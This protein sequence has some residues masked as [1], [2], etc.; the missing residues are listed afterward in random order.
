[1][2]YSTASYS[3]IRRDVQARDFIGD[4]IILGEER[5]AIQPGFKN[6]I[7]GDTWSFITNPENFGLERKGVAIEAVR[8]GNDRTDG[9]YSLDWRLTFDPS[10]SSTKEYPLVVMDIRSKRWGEVLVEIISHKRFTMETPNCPWTAIMKIYFKKGKKA[11]KPAAILTVDSVPL[12]WTIWDL[13]TPMYDAAQQTMERGEQKRKRARER[14]RMKMGLVDRKGG[15]LSPASI[16]DEKRGTQ[17]AAPV[18]SDVSKRAELLALPVVDP[19][20]ISEPE[21]Q[22]PKKVE[23]YDEDRQYFPD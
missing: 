3:A 16:L 2:V 7:L 18:P 9:I 19:D 15:Y 10:F 20:K 23:E 1:M 6:V 12:E 13:L 17:H 22:E 4:L 8:S 5:E 11:G 21:P 14:A